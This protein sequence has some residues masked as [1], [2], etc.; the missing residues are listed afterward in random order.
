MKKRLALSVI[1]FILIAL[2]AWRII[3]HT[4][5]KPNETPAQ[6]DSIDSFAKNVHLTTLDKSG[7]I[8]SELQASRLVHYHQSNQTLLQRPVITLY[9]DK[10]PPWIITA[11]QGEIHHD[12]E[13]ILLEHQ[14]VIHQNSGANNDEV[15]IKTPSILVYP[16][17][18]IALSQDPVE[19][20]SP[21]TH[22]QGVGLEAHFNEG[23][24]ELK[25]QAK[26][27]YVLPT[28]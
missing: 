28:T 23:S 10:Q 17:T 1:F 27:H 9:T 8:S 12:K 14:V 2:L 25:N 4:K 26:G 18:R 3:H 20:F 19:L 22:I 24:L 16:N 7:H 13:E 5:V 15:S 21:N 11:S 6:A